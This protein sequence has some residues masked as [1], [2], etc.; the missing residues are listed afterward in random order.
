MSTKQKTWEN[1]LEDIQPDINIINGSLKK[2]KEKYPFVRFSQI[3]EDNQITIIVNWDE[4]DFGKQMYDGELNHTV[5]K[6]SIDPICETSK[7]MGSFRNCA[8]PDEN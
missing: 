7:S 5:Y 4:I 3:S 6:S 2:I 8:S 1:F